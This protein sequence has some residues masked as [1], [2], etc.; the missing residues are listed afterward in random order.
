MLLHSY[1][2]ASPAKQQKGKRK[3]LSEARALLMYLVFSSSIKIVIYKIVTISVLGG[4]VLCP[5][6]STG[7]RISHTKRY[8]FK[9]LL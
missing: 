5:C 9:I 2:F 8:D 1:C 7:C 4:N 6:S 3:K